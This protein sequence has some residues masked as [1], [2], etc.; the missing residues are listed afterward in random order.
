MNDALLGALI[1]A[2]SAVAGAGVGPWLGGRQ[3]RRKWLRDKRAVALEELQTAIDTA[4][5]H[6][7]D[8]S[9]TLRLW[10]N[11]ADEQDATTR[12]QIVLD[13]GQPIRDALTRQVARSKVYTSQDFH[14]HA[15]L[16]R[17][18]Y[19]RVVTPFSRGSVPTKQDRDRLLSYCQAW[20]DKAPGIDKQIR[21]ELDVPTGYRPARKM[22]S[23]A[24]KTWRTAKS[25]GRS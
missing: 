5:D 14:D 10:D 7:I 12:L 11:Y 1:G 25:L 13:A 8:V 19:D 4:Y 17:A 22:R 2:G 6:V 18:Y 16:I 24:T 20:L 21:A 9:A 23:V 3:E 15:F